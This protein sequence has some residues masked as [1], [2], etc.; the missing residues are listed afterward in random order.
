M[1]EGRKDRSRPR[2]WRDEGDFAIWQGIES[3]RR[4]G[5]VGGVEGRDTIMA[6]ELIERYIREAE[7]GHLWGMIQLDFQDGQITLV[8]RTETFKP[9]ASRTREQPA[10][11]NRPASQTR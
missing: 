5:F 3:D 4:A 7:A 2:G 11:G 9:A 8:R 6:N 10:N 1:P